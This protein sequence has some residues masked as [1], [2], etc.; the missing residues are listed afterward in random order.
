MAKDKISKTMGNIKGKE[1]NFTL[2]IKYD[3]AREAREAREARQLKDKKNKNKKGK[4]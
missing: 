4:K 3:K 1:S 2:G